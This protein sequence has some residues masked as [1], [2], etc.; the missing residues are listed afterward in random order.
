MNPINY[1]THGAMLAQPEH[2]KRFSPMKEENLSSLYGTSHGSLKVYEYSLLGIEIMLCARRH[3]P[4]QENKRTLKP[5][6]WRNGGAN[7][8]LTMFAHA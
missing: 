5:T 6:P 7:Q 8:I 4:N 1:T 2:K 3:E